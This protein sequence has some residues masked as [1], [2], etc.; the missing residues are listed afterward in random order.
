MADF[1]IAK[2][3][4]TWKGTW[5]ATTHYV[6]DDIVYYGGKSYVCFVTHVASTTFLADLTATTPRWVLMFDGGS[7][8]GVWSTATLYNPGDMVKY[9]GIVYRAIT[10][11]TSAATTVLGL[12]AT[13]S[14]WTT[15]AT[16][17]DWKNVWN[18]ATQ[19]KIND[20]VKYGAQVY[21][22]VTN[23]TSTTIAEEGLE[24]DLSKWEVVV[25]QVEF[26]GE[27]TGSTRYKINDVVRYG[28]TLWKANTKHTS[29]A[30][31][32]TVEYWDVYLDGLQWDAVPWQ[33][34]ITYQ[35]GDI[36]G[37]GGY[38][39][40]ALQ[41]HSGQQPQATASTYWGLVTENYEFKGSW[42]A[43]TADPVGPLEYKVGDVV[44][45][46]GYLYLAI[47]NNTGVEP[48][49]LTYWKVL[50]QGNAWRGL[51]RLTDPDPVTAGLTIPVAF[52]LGDLATQ[53][54]TTYECKLA[55][56]ASTP[57]APVTD[58]AGAGTYWKIYVEGTTTNVLAN[59][60][61]IAWFDAGVKKRLP[62]GTDGQLLR[63]SASGALT[64]KSW[65][66]IPKVYYVAPTGTD[67]ELLGFGVSLDKPF[68]TVKYACEHVTGPAT[69]FIKTGIYSEVL[70]I[71]IPADV[72][73]VGDE[74]RSTVIQPAAGYTT[75]NMFFVRNGSG[76]RNMTLQG[77]NGT[78]GPFN[79]YLTKRPT[80]GAFVSLDPTGVAIV[81][82]RISTKSP[83][84]QNVTTIGTGC[85]GLKV[86]GALHGGGNKSI[87]A[88][89]FTQVISDGIGCWIT[90]Q[91]KAE[92][93]SCFT[94]YCHI[95][96]L[97]E[98]GG[99][100]R[101]TNGNNSYGDFGAVSEGSNTDEVPITG[102]VN[103]RSQQASVGSVFTNGSQIIAL[104][105]VN[106]G[107]N[108][109]TS[110]A[111]TFGGS[112]SGAAVSAATVTDGGIF[113]IRLRDPLNGD[114]A[115]GSGFI[116]VQAY[117]QEGTTNGTITI[118][119]GDSNV[120]ANYLGMRV[121]IISGKGAGQY[122]YVQAY[123]PTT[124]VATIYKE[125]DGTQGWDHFL[126][127][128]DL[129]ALD[130]TSQYSIEPRVV[131]AAPASGTRAIARVAVS[132]GRIGVFRIINPGSGYNSSTPP[133]VTLTSPGQSAATYTVRVGD[134]VL[135]QP[136]YSNS[137]TAYLTATATVSG[138]GYADSFQFGAY[139][140]VSNISV[141][142]TPG[143]NIIIS[144][145]SIVYRL[146][147]V[148]QIS[149][150]GPFSCRLQLNPTLELKDAPAHAASVQIR[151]DYSQN[152]LTGHDWL[153][154]GTGNFST[155][156]YPNQDT[157]TIRS[158]NLAVES[159]GGRCFYTATDQD[160][161][162]RVGNLF[163]VEQASGIATLNASFFDLNG[164][165]QLTL[166]GIVLGGTSATITEISTDATLPLN[167]DNIIV[168]QRALKSYISS[169]IGGGGASLNANT[170][171]SGQISFN[172]TTVG[173]T[174]SSN[175]TN[176]DP[177][178]S[179][180][181]AAR[182]NFTGGVSGSMMA[183]AFFIAQSRAR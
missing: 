153:E 41:I 5:S 136:T 142:P 82:A 128:S 150:S 49:N 161:N 87:V 27:W 158:G 165:T 50:N 120:Q 170:V 16:T 37:Y 67:N 127:G 69:I 133:V 59:Q 138:V 168:T 98:N 2:I 72:A 48:P 180:E 140:Y 97:A 94:Y 55:H 102:I 183:S 96:Y 123:N 121:V 75:A 157:T 45:L 23:H 15:L 182:V 147:T 172:Q 12:E 35:K 66:V 10:S 4:Y 113:E 58:I 101:A 114:S 22:C 39:Y 175:I 107:Q 78:L 169:R 53:G 139:L 144:G 93:V 47:A 13:Q 17:E 25:Q 7:W 3:R 131:I 44:R 124:K 88:N 167:S 181:F 91:G 51:W 60:G 105:Y 108:Y 177:T 32:F 179:I 125:T 104:E 149:G 62:V 129:F 159:G 33:P 6:R 34:S 38:V 134:G 145:A 148:S 9:G 173:A 110:T 146:V 163:K 160:G 56:I 31:V 174:V 171:V 119:A 70:P 81:A 100:I 76:I 130:T 111:Y 118:N 106:A 115:G 18:T 21:R 14:A 80:A 57:T 77:L 154:V 68:Q 52:K 152:R 30:S 90:N 176:T 143:A 86:D 61:D 85:T 19:Y 109:N 162:Y 89:D 26:K 99:K 112:G 155:T 43:T 71:T 117:A 92:L 141:V 64:Y 103:N 40:R 24:I 132:G 116:N 8:K 11:H 79:S 29:L 122:G 74:L 126:P 164:L 73:L 166:G 178:K 20:I 28:G 156:N 83:Y 151:S 137:G 63:A 1:K 65:G 42:S 46:G 84:I 54:S 135:G 36:I 95:G